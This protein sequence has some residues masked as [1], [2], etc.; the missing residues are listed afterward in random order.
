MHITS[1]TSSKH[2]FGN[3]NMTSNCDV[4]NSAH[5]IQM[6][7]IYHW[8]KTP[9]KFSAYAIGWKY[10]KVLATGLTKRQ[11][12]CVESSSYKNTKVNFSLKTCK[13]KHVSHPGSG[14]QRSGEAWGDFL[15][16]CPLTKFSPWA[17]AYGGHC[18]CIYTV[19]DV[20]LWRHIHVCKPMFWQVCWQ[21]MHTILYTLSLL[22]VVQCV[23]VIN[24]N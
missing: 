15:I 7:A 24:V 14:V 9:R 4:T 22:A 19:C 11:T 21:S 2:W 13:R 5:Q 16:V 17:T 1:T 23:T 3:R 20:T 18:Y 10:G 6:T 8:M 12:C